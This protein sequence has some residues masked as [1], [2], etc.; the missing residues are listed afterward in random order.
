M[1]SFIFAHF[2]AT[3]RS[4]EA[5]EEVRHKQWVV[6]VIQIFEIHQ[7]FFKDTPLF[8]EGTPPKASSPM[9]RPKMSPLQGISTFLSTYNIN[10]FIVLRLTPRLVQDRLHRPLP[11]SS[12][13]RPSSSRIHP[14]GRL[15]RGHAP[16]GLHF[17]DTPPNVCSRENISDNKFELLFLYNSHKFFFHERR[18]IFDP[19]LAS[20]R[21]RILNLVFY[22]DKWSS[23]RS[24]NRIF[25]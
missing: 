4:L 19:E 23:H 15:L 6:I 13:T 2:S 3:T 9:T 16:K 10:V 7:F 25:S 18:R 24:F 21:L 11:S 14:R 22:F 5:S 20:Y 8:F 17:K 12:R 1:S